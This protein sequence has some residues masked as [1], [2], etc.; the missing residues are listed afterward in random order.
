MPSQKSRKWSFTL[1]NPTP[2]EKESIA[3]AEDRYTYC[4]VG[5]EVGESGTPHLQG[6]I[7]FPSQVRMNTVK[8]VVGV[9]AHVEMSRGTVKQNYDYCSKDKDFTEY[10]RRP[11]FQEEKGQAEKDR[12]KRA[13]ALSTQGD[14]ETLVEE[15]PDI[16]I[17]HYSTLKK[18]RM[19]AV[20]SRKLDNLSD[21]SGMH[22]YWGPSGTGKSHKARIENPD[23]YLKDVNK[24]WC[25]YT[26]QETVILEDLDV[27]NGEWI[28]RFLK[29]WTDIYPFPADMKFGKM[30]IRPKKFI[31]TSNYHPDQIWTNGP[32]IEPVKRRFNIT[33]F[34]QLGIVGVHPPVPP[35]QEEDE[36]TEDT[37]I[38][39][40]TQ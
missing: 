25:G 27:R 19:D 17:R 21:F 23:A 36:E 1:N 14:M 32:D 6:F 8:S 12:Y 39:D 37:E 5:N 34:S 22:W 20:S 16:A 30:V 28:I 4:I 10:G 18:I 24:W 15:M 3:N 38:I 40:L 31:V 11:A 26:D 9:R 2:A 35:P 29:I 13:W 7:Y 33:H